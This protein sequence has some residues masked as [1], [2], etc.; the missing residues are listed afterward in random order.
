MKIKE[1][2]VS[3]KVTVTYISTN[4]N[5]EMNLVHLPIP[6]PIALSN[7]IKVWQSKQN[8][9]GDIDGDCEHLINPRYLKAAKL[10]C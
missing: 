5:H 8:W 3:S 1:D 10:M 6:Q 9:D 4:W 2:T 7:Y